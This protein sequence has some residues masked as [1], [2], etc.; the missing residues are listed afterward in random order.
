MRPRRGIL[1]SDDI[2]ANDNTLIWD[3]STFGSPFQIEVNIA[4]NF[5]G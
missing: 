5:A 3:R 2:L 1:E 4:Y